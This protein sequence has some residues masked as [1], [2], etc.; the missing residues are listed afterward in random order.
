MDRLRDATKGA[1]DEAM[2]P[3]ERSLENLKTVTEPVTSALG[4]MAT[5]IGTS[6][7]DAITDVTS[8]LTKNA[9]RPATDGLAGG[10]VIDNYAAG[11][12][13]YG[14]GQVDPRYSSG[15]DIMTP[16]GNIDASMKIFMEAM[17]KANDN[18]D[19][20]LAYYSGNTPGSAG[21][22]KY[23]TA[24]R[25]Y[26]IDTLPADTSSL[27]DQEAAR[28]NFPKRFT[29]LYKAVIGHESGGHQYADRKAASVGS[30]ES[31]RH[32]ISA[33][34][35]DNPKSL[36]AG[37]SASAGSVSETSWTQQRGAL[38][39]YIASEEKLLATQKEGSAAWTQ[40]KE[41]ITQA[42]VA[43]ANTLSPQ[44]KI[45]QGLNDSLAPLQAQTGYW[46]SM[47]EV[48]AQFDQTARG[49]GV[50][51]QA[52]TQLWQTNRPCS[53]PPMKMA[54]LRLNA[55]RSR[56]PQLLPLRVDRVRRCNT[57]RTTRWPIPR[58]SMIL[59]HPAP[60]SCRQ[61]NAARRRSMPHPQP[62]CGR[63]SSRRMRAC[64]TRLP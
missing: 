34:V 3:F 48:V 1:H 63:S 7:M 30:T 35:I 33:A 32:A 39:D 21:A 10:D 47:A 6:L 27:I 55:R 56:K 54:R 12:H 52:L 40:T 23:A 64:P 22:S 8:Y 50:E 4:R 57:R 11:Q 38:E 60:N 49:T 46:R 5:G 15:Y 2:T 25:G 37:A 62:R 18:R 26:D 17:K 16:K 44:E 53:L 43:L 13:H 19:N 24:V 28:L 36:Q 58:R 41:Q 20:T 14:L 9:R 31:V 51:Q 29:N 42:R 59:T 45:T 61:W